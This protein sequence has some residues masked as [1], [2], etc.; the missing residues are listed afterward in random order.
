MVRECWAVCVA[1]GLMSMALAN[2]SDVGAGRWTPEELLNRFVPI[3]YVED[4]GHAA[5]GKRSEYPCN[6]L[7]AGSGSAEDVE[8]N[9]ETIPSGWNPDLYTVYG[10][11]EEKVGPAPN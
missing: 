4:V 11:A 8:D 9:F 5:E 2:A 7:E 10:C 6:M 1:I 3:V